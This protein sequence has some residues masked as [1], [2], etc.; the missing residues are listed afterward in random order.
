MF[1]PWRSRGQLVEV[2]QP[3]SLSSPKRTCE[4]LAHIWMHR[5]WNGFVGRPPQPSKP[6]IE[7]EGPDDR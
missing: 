7:L 2:N 1:S 6:G 3:Q 4:Q 5:T